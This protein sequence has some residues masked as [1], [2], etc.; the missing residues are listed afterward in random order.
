MF[1]GI[2]IMPGRTEVE[3][4]HIIFRLCGTPSEEYWRKLNLSTTFRPPKSYRPS[5][6]ESFRDLPPSS[7]GLLCTLLTLDPAYRGTASKALQNPFF[8]TIP[9]ACELS[10][11]PVI[12]KEDDGKNLTNE[13]IKHVN[14]KFRRSHSLH[15]SRRKN[16]VSGWQTEHTVSSEEELSNKVEAFVPYNEEKGS[17]PR[18]S[19]T[20]SV[21]NTS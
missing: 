19:M 20:S 12:Y 21:S 7:V 2:P 4:L 11:L 3:Q 16:L 9:L 18:S 17:I 14:S 10:G 5:L 15:E 8:F 13:Q 6:A 1:K